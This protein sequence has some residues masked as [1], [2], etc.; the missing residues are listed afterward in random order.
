MLTEYEM[1]TTI[2]DN[3]SVAS[4]LAKPFW[5]VWAIEMWERFGYYGMQA[6]LSLYFVQQ[7]GYSEKQSFYIF[8]SF[9]AFS[10]GF[11]WV[12]GWIGDNY[13][14]AKRTLTLGAV[15]LMLS[16]V[17]LALSNQQTIFFALAG[18]AVGNALFKAN[19]SSLISKMYAKGDAKLD[20]AMTL[21]YMAIN[22]GSMLS[23][24]VTPIIAR[25]YGWPLAF[26]LCSLGLLL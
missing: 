10:Y 17:A 11:I 2:T 26:S 25:N 4:R 18:I 16:Y 6:I 21:Y 12:G 23:M 3:I 19:P 15:I 7:L 1:E 24:A 5:V 8:G 14:G 9:S 13:L 20:G 22:V